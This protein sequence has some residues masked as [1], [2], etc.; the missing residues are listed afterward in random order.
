MK[1]MTETLIR[2]PYV[3]EPT[4]ETAK[5]GHKGIGSVLLNKYYALQDD[6][7]SFIIENEASIE[8]L[9]IDTA[10][11]IQDKSGLAE[12]GK[13]SQ[14][15]VDTAN[16]LLTKDYEFFVDNVAELL[17]FNKKRKLLIKHKDVVMVTAI[18]KFRLLSDWTIENTKNSS[19]LQPGLFA[20][21][22]KFAE[23]EESGE[24][25][26]LEESEVEAEEVTE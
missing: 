25:E 8:K 5:I 24:F 23:R 12:N 20:E 26:E 18:I 15:T 1:K 21:L 2:L 11:A 9:A 14:L 13:S 6:E 7:I 19:L 10:K 22:L 4:Q 17:E 16:A 3:I